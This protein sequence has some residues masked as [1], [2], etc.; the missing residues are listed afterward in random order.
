ML[1][2]WVPT[3]LITVGSGHK[4]AIEDRKQLHLSAKHVHP[5][6]VF[7]WWRPPY[8]AFDRSAVAKAK[9]SS[10]ARPTSS[11]RICTFDST[12]LECEPSADARR[13][14]GNAREKA[15]KPAL[16]LPARQLGIRRSYY[17]MRAWRKNPRRRNYIGSIQLSSRRPGSSRQPAAFRQRRYQASGPSTLYNRSRSSYATAWPHVCPR[18]AAAIGQRRIPHDQ[19]LL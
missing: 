1:H 13:P 11:K 8:T 15:C 14:A 12:W 5:F 6:C 7:N 2:L 9:V 17:K 4:R 3:T 10:P 16:V 18:L 19:G